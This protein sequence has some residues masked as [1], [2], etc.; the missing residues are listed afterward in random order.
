MYNWSNVLKEANHLVA[1][2]SVEG[3]GNPALG[4]SRR[5][6]LPRQGQAFA[7]VHDREWLSLG[8][9]EVDDMFE[10]STQL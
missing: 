9:E 3:R 10:G 5:M 2:K 4:G 8:S 1:L 6:P 7:E